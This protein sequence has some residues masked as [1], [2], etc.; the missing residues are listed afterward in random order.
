MA[1]EKKRSVTID[2]QKY[3]DGDKVVVVITG[4]IRVGEPLYWNQ[5][6]TEV[7]VEYGPDFHEFY[8]TDAEDG[9]TS[10]KDDGVTLVK[11]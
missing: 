9:E 11:P 4:R 8:L 2:G 10:A 3:K 1:K 6:T 7:H 5:K